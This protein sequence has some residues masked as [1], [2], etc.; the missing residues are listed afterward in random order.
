MKRYF[1]KAGTIVEFEESQ[2]TYQDEK[3][4]SNVKVACMRCGGL[5]RIQ[6]YGHVDGGICFKCQGAKYFTKTYKLRTLEEA[7]KLQA[8][9]MDKKK[10]EEQEK[11]AQQMQEF[12]EQYDKLSDMYVVFKNSYQHK[13]YLKAIGYKFDPT[14]KSWYG[15]QEPSEL[16]EGFIKISKEDFYK[17]N[18]EWLHVS[19]NLEN[20][21]NIIKNEE[22]KD[23]SYYGEVGK[24]YEDTFKVETIKIIEGQY[25]SHLVILSQG[26]YKLTCFTNAYKVLNN[27]EIG[28]EYKFKFTIKKQEEYNGA[29]TTYI[30][31]IKLM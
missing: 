27:I 11:R 3:G 28:N 31:K 30:T 9:Y 24:T 1:Y 8:K 20:I 21:L 13:D 22:T 23:S 25:S 4:N 17:V 26:N 16:N 18:E 10:K 2:I 19:L 6:H 29:K 5:G 12:I 14:L 7:E 15:M